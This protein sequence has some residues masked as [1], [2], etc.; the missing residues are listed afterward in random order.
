MGRQKEFD[1]SGEEEEMTRLRRRLTKEPY[2]KESSRRRFPDTTSDYG[3]ANSYLHHSSAAHVAASGHTMYSVIFRYSPDGIKVYFRFV[4]YNYNPNGCSESNRQNSGRGSIQPN[5]PSPRL[6]P[7]VT[8]P[9]GGAVLLDLG[10]NLAD[11]SQPSPD[12]F[13]SCVA[14]PASVEA[15]FEAP[16]STPLRRLFVVE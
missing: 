10:A 7:P 13:W 12:P 4:Q 14:G 2:P 5:S 9:P 11:L 8:L 3:Q 6:L 1:L 15:G 16:M